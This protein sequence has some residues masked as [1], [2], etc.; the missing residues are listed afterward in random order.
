MVS[1]PGWRT[2]AGPSPVGPAL[3]N[4]R[5]KGLAAP[6][7]YGEQSTATASAAQTSRIRSSAN[8]PTLSTRTA[9]DT[10]STESRLTAQRRG[11]G[12]CPGSR[13]TSLASPRII[14]VH[15]ATTARRSLGIAASRDSTM[16]GRRPISDNSHHHTSPRFGSGV[17]RRLPPS[18]T[19][20]DRPTRQ[21]D[22][23][24][25][26]HTR[27]S[28]RRSR[29]PD[30]APGGLAARRPPVRHRSARSDGPEPLPAAKRRLWCST[31][32]GP[33]HKYAT[34]V[35]RVPVGIATT[36]GAGSAGSRRP[37]PQRRAA[38]PVR[39]PAVRRKHRR[40]ADT[41][42]AHSPRAHP[43]CV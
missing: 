29:V 39:L 26:R 22:S 18:A 1:A 24:A 27:R 3:E 15:G 23:P 34:G 41:I 28:R 14:V 30:S 33:C 17:T 20:R 11:I 5:K 35:R 37:R 12:S 40:P 19:S 31:V 32:C 4:D 10:L 9:T 25:F 21:A 7:C 8:R 43:R 2:R 36:T 38:R 16:T 13:T 42:P 6:C